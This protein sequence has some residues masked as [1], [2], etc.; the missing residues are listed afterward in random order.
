MSRDYE[1]CFARVPR[2]WKGRW[3]LLR[4]FTR[5][6]HGADVGPVGRLP[7][8]VAREEKKLGLQLP[9]SFREWISFADELIAKGLFSDLLRDC[10]EVKRLRE[11]RAI[12]LMIQGESDAY[13]AVKECNLRQSDPPVEYYALDYEAD[14]PTFFHRSQFAS[15]ITS[16]VLIHMAHLCGKG[17]AFGASVPSRTTVNELQAAFPVASAFGELIV[18]ENTNVFGLVF[19]DCYGDP[20]Q[21]RIIV[22]AYKPPFQR[23][24]PKKALA[25]A[26]DYT[27]TMA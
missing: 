1:P 16:F 21:Q 4:E 3:E 10:Y 6:W 9:P 23:W 15:R 22:A 18:L 5:R 13:W 7:K 27:R 17:G 25:L 8:R 14:N 11:H 26:P 24:V 2:T 12:S 20:K 19:P